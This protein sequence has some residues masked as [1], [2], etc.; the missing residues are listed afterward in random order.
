[1]KKIL[2][3]ICAGVVL[4]AALAS[5]QDQIDE[6][7]LNPEK[8]TNPSIGK[9]F[10]YM[11]DNSRVRAEYWNI[12]TFLVMH[13]GVYTQSVTFI[14]TTKRFQQQPSYLDD[15]WRDYYTPTAGGVVSHMREI[16]KEYA[17]L[18]DADKANAEV[19][20]QAARVLYYDQTAQM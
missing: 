4:V 14:N 17:T 6:Q 15:Y 16:E 1:M 7:F 9:F 5:C 19:Y 10:T 11:I 20:L 3:A 12:R 8:T 2:K 18:S 13:P